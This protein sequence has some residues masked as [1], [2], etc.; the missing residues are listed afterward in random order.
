MTQQPD[1]QQWA[2]ALHER[3]AQAIRDARQGISAQQLADATKR[4]GYPISRNQIANY[5]SH[6]KQTLDVAELIVLAT[7]LRVPPITL[8][9]GGHP[10][11]EVEVLPGQ[12]EPMVSALAWFTGDDSLADSAVAEPDSPAAKLLRLTR[13]RA[14]KQQSLDTAGRMASF[15][16]DNQ[17]EAKFTP[18]IELALAA[19]DDVEEVDAAIDKQWSA[20]LAG[21][22]EVTE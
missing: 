5:E 13:R 16:A 8:L 18:A 2:K 1:P 7:A 19:M 21:R 9:F 17:D 10:N 22:K 6:R 3:I 20:I 15:F 11:D 4:L 14:E 12:H